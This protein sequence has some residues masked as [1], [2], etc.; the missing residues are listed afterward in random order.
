[1]EARGL[2][3][4]GVIKAPVAVLLTL[5]TPSNDGLTVTEVSRISGVT[6]N[7]VSMAL[8][9]LERRRLAARH[10]PAR[11]Q[12]LTRSY[13]TPAGLDAARAMVSEIQKF[14]VAAPMQDMCHTVA[15]TG[16]VSTTSFMKGVAH[17]NS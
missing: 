16:G 17:M 3:A 11:D 1:M 4:A 14:A 7:G 2:F 9:G 8:T 10:H 6:I 12:R 13:L 5:Y 15:G